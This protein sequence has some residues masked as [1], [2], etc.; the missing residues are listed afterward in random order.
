MLASKAYPNVAM[1]KKR[2]ITA[3]DLDAALLSTNNDPS[4]VTFDNGVEGAYNAIQDFL[5]SRITNIAS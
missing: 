1:V 3:D 5:E 2:K 4:S